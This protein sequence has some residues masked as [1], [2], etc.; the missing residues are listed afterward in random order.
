LATLGGERKRE[1]GVRYNI[2]F[3]RLVCLDLEG[4]EETHLWLTSPERERKRRKG[5]AHL[6]KKEGRVVPD[7]FPKRK[8]DGDDHRGP[9]GK[10]KERAD[11]FPKP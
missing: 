3:Q 7:A 5:T 2:P 9:G 11:T 6:E 4:K 10:E 1:E 8:G